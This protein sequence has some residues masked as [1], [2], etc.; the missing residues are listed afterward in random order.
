MVASKQTLV[1]LPVSAAALPPPL[2]LLTAA[3]HG[4]AP[5]GRFL[6]TL[7]SSSS[8]YLFSLRVCFC[9]SVVTLSLPLPMVFRHGQTILPV[10]RRHDTPMA[11]VAS[12]T[13]S[14]YGPSN[15]GQ[16]FWMLGSPVEP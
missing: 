2:P 15:D 11:A 7:A 8:F 5:L 9:V 4:L 6:S 12:Q 13:A 3:E 14:L 10:Y 16:A 1:P